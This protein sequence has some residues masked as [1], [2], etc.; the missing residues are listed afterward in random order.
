MLMPAGFCQMTHF[1]CTNTLLQT[2]TP[3]RLRGR[4]MAIYSMMLVGMAPFGAFFAGVVAQKLGAPVTVL[5]GATGCLLG[6]FAF[7]SRL[8][9]FHPQVQRLISARTGSEF[10]GFND[11][12]TA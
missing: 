4:V 10:S 12:R 7:L 11:H 2:I 6:A 8:H 3:D 1:A 5:L 9:I